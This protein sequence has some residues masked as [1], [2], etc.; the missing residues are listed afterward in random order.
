M[1]RKA[2]KEDLPA[3]QKVYEAA[4]AYMDAS[5]NPNQWAV[6]YPGPVLEEDLAKDQLYVVCGEDGTIHA[7]FVFALG[8]DPTYAVIEN[9]AWT[10][11][12]PYGTIHRVGSDGTLKGVV[13]QCLNFCKGIIH[14]I[15]ADTHHDNKTMQHQLEKCGFKPCGIIHVADGSPRIAY[16]YFA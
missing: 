7:G 14:Y 10:G 2:Q 16:E 9:G 13:P 15:R 12:G 1:I 8:D 5:G 3:L 11:E 6:G 4:K